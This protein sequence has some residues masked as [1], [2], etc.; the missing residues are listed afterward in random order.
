ME[1][2]RIIKPNRP[3]QLEELGTPKAKGSQVLVKVES[4]GVCHSDLHLWEGGHEGVKGQFLKT[5]DRGVKLPLTPGHKVAGVTD[6]LGEEA[7]DRFNKDDRVLIYPCIDERLCPTCRAAEE[8]LCNKPR[9]LGIYNGGGYADYFLVPSYRYVVRI[10]NDIEM[11]AVA[12]LSCSALTTY[13]A[14]KKAT[15]RPNDNVV[16]VGAGGLCLMA[17]QLIKPIIGSKIIT[18]DLEN[19]KLMS[20]YII[21]M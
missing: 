13:S 21:I 12:T 6:S 18:L 16:I 7:K 19:E 11:D 1:A 3:L 10:G 20:S 8:N 4:S 17:I 5:T 9:S 15:L 14:V 2:A